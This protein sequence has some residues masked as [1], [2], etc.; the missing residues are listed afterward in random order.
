MARRVAGDGARADGPAENKT[1]TRVREKPE[2]AQRAR[3]RTSDADG[4]KQ[5]RPRTR[6]SDERWRQRDDHVEVRPR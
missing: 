6:R 4:T 5:E 3:D 1:A 2:S